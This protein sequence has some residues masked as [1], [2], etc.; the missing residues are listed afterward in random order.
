MHAGGGQRE[1]SQNSTWSSWA[2]PVAE[3][4]FFQG[5]LRVRRIQLLRR[6]P[7]ILP[8]SIP[9]LVSMREIALGV[10]VA[11]SAGAFLRIVR[12]TVSEF[13]K[14]PLLGNLGGGSSHG[15]ILGTV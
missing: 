11:G 5:F 10:G 6:V 8:V 1:T 12:V 14:K 4:I 7:G 13:R 15:Q 3:K 2:S 9:G